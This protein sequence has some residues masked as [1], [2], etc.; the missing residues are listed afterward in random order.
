ME[1]K[2]CI[3]CGREFPITDEYWY[4]YLKRNG[5]KGYYNACRQCKKEQRKKSIINAIAQPHEELTEKKCVECGRIL[6]IE[7]FIRKKV[8]IKSGEKTY[9]STFCRECAG[10][11]KSGMAVE[12]KNGKKV[13]TCKNSC[14]WYP[15]FQGIDN[16]TS[17]LAL[18]CQRYK[19]KEQ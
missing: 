15:C 5:T 12:V 11:H 10:N 18:T 6:P 8:M 13:K 3:K 1:S 17:N 16:I 2:V 4:P 9:Y 19:E 14:K 7:K